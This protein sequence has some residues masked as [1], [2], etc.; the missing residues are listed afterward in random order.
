MMLGHEERVRS[1]IVAFLAGE[2]LTRTGQTG[3]EDDDTVESEG[4]GPPVTTLTG[5]V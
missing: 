3:P 1:E 5:I 2:R 4:E